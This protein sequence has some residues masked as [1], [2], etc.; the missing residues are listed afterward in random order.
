MK[1]GE[2]MKVK[3]NLK[4]ILCMMVLVV[5]LVSPCIS[6]EDPEKFPSK[7]I[8]YV[9]VWSPGGNT[10]LS[11]RKLC[12]LA[13]RFLGQK[14]VV[15]NKAGGG[16]S[17]GTSVLARAKPDGYTMGSASISPLIF[18]SQLRKVPYHPKRDFTFIGNYLEATA[19]LAVLADAPWKTFK[20]FV[21][22]AKR[23]PGKLTYSSP[24]PTTVYYFCMETILSMAGVKV[25]HVPG[26]GGQDAV[27]LG[28]GGH[29]KSVFT[30]EVIPQIRAGKMR[31]LA[32]L[33][34]KRR[35]EF[36]NVPTFDELGYAGAMYIWSGIGAPKGL[37]PRIRKKLYDAF[38]KAFKDP[39]FQEF[40]DKLGLGAVWMDSLSFEAMVYR[41]FD[42]VAKILKRSKP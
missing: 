13:G 11:S 17:I 37:D 18:G 39:S 21:E 3:I 2:K 32:V 31:G 15:V 8:E 33:A 1:G 36:P 24:G 16:G 19:Y 40:M 10:D 38:E 26:K 12:D 27:M 22:D 14:I 41:D 28:L 35:K 7:P 20:D 23:N 6:A 5:M 34:K 4:V 29:T 30:P 42:S 25:S 9:V